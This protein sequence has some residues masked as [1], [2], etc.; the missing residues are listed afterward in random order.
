MQ[1]YHSSAEILAEDARRRSRLAKP[2]DPVTGLNAGGDRFLL[3]LSD[4]L[5]SDQYLPHSMSSEPLIVRLLAEGS[6]ATVA[7]CLGKTPDEVIES[8]VRLR[9]RHDFPFWAAMTALI[10]NKGGGD[11]KSVV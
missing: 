6:V 9:F 7:R 10:K 5:L 2:V 11:R 1:T 3:H 8:M 4:C